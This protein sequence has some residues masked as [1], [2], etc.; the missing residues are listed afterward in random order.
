M[1]NNFFSGTLATTL[2][3][4][5]QLEFID[6]S[7]NAFL[8]GTLPN[9]L[10]GLQQVRNIYL[11]NCSLA[12]TLPANYGTPPNLRDL[13]L[14]GNN[15]VGTVPEVSTGQLTR[16]NEFLIQ[17]NDFTGSM[18]ASI[19]VLRD[20]STGILEDLWSDCLGNPAQIACDFPGCCNR[21]FA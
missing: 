3:G 6:L 15:F 4:A 10:F 21:C 2:F 16:L 9:S 20:N 7:N 11:A 5:S 8:S 17:N 18:P 14:D 19:C 12:G 1:N 13:F